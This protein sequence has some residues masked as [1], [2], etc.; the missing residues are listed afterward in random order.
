MSKSR[1]KGNYNGIGQ[2]LRLESVEAVVAEQAAG[3][4]SRCGPG[5]ELDIQQGAHRKVYSIG[6]A[7]PE[8]R[9]DNLENNTLLKARGG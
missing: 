2:L 8:A 7:T 6:T 5:Y 9:A 3:V 1:L 4:L